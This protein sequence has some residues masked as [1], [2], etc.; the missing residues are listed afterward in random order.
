MRTR[1][2]SFLGL[3]VIW[4]IGSRFATDI[5]LPGP[6]RV[7]TDFV[8]L[9]TSG[10][11][12][13]ALGLTLVSLLTG[14]GLAAIAGIPLG[15][16]MGARARLGRA[17]DPM[18]S[19]LY[20]MPFSAVAP[21]FV[22]WFGIDATARTIFV[23]LFTLPQI[24]IVCYQGA[25]ATPE[26]LLE[27]GRAYGANEWD[28]FRKVIVPHELPF[29]FTA[30]R[31]GVGR[32]VQGM[33]VAE[34]VITAVGGLGYLI[35]VNSAALNLSAV[36]ALILFLMLLGV[37]LTLLVQRIENSVAPWHRGTALEPGAVDG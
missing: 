10:R 5:V 29:V 13:S 15:L 31:L 16:A 9:A 28:L 20:I 35:K 1:A 34:L 17:L 37:T 21:L 2:V 26:R 11:L 14:G 23:F 32:A 33:V 22:L 30:L 27:V 18:L 6:D 8:R 4:W 19:A 7:T 36:L 12:A 3:L 24:A 25:R